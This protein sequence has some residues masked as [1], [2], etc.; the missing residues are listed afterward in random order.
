MALLHLWNVAEFVGILPVDKALNRLNEPIP[1][2][3]TN[4]FFL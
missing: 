2:S 1:K 3:E 4:A